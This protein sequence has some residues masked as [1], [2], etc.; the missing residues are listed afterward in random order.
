MLIK[1]TITFSSLYA[2]Y[3]TLGFSLNL[4]K[5]SGKINSYTKHITVPFLISCCH[6]SVCL[7]GIKFICITDRLFEKLG[8][9]FAFSVF[10][11]QY[12]FNWW[13]SPTV[14]FISFFG[15]EIEDNI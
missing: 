7:L 6:A 12:M 10:D 13:I 5:S 3:S 8:L 2:I 11:V 1:E 4:N 14:I 9:A 15:A